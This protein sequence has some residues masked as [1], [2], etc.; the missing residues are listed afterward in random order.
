MR[1]APSLR[2]QDNLPD[3]LG[4]IEEEE[5]SNDEQP[6][7]EVLQDSSGQQLDRREVRLDSDPDGPITTP[8]IEAEA[9]RPP[10][11]SSAVHESFGSLDEVPYG[12]SC[13]ETNSV[14]SPGIPIVSHEDNSDW[15]AISPSRTS[16]QLYGRNQGRNFWINGI[17][18]PAEGSSPF[19]LSTSSVVGC[20]S[21][22]S[23]YQTDLTVR[24]RPHLRELTPTLEM[25][26]IQ[27][28]ISQCASWC[29]STDNERH[30]S[31]K[32]V[33]H[34]MRCGPWRAA[35]MAISSRQRDL[36]DQTHPYQLSLELYQSA[37]KALIEAVTTVKVESGVLAGCVLLTVYEMMTVTYSDWERHLEG[38]AGIFRANNWNGSTRG[39]VGCCFWAY[40]RI[41]ELEQSVFVADCFL[42]S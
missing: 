28:Y 21:E 2:A 30:F 32:E 20:P 31:V 1:G 26:L 40:A 36:S 17:D 42:D 12:C 18:E 16:N 39:L 15:A 41:G 27:N 35:A 10:T 3:V 33:H 13:N 19:T 25:S 4:R 14:T 9:G 24:T 23:L 7:P 38:C 37:V 11:S 34:M 6:N 22:T 29:E 5:A 8:D